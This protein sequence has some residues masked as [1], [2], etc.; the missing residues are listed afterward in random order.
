MQNQEIQEFNSLPD[1]KKERLIARFKEKVERR[2]KK[3]N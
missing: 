3:V 1:K 2:L